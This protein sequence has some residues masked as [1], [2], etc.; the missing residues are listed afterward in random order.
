MALV[1]HGGVKVE[2]S[3]FKDRTDAG[4]KLAQRLIHYAGRRNVIVL[5]LPRGGVPVGNEVAKALDVPLDIFLVRKL[6]SPGQEELAMG[7]IASGGIR[8][9]NEDVVKLLVIRQDEIERVAAREQQELARREHVYRGDRP[10]PVLRDQTIIL[11]D[12]GLATGTTMRAAVVAIR[13]QR[14]E[15]IVV[16]VPTAPR[17]TC[18]KFENEVDEII[19]ATTPEH[20]RALGEWYED[21]RQ[22]TDEEVRSLLGKASGQIHGVG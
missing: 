1:L 4:R 19:C 9:L 8:V 14:P 12:D 7:A 13:S 6:G 5:A 17:E 16:A 21:F 11:V 22:T 20:F 15:R 3:L 18:Q 10:M 2:Y